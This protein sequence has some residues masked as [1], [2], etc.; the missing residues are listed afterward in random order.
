MKHFTL[1]ALCLAC[2]FFEHCIS[3]R[4]IRN[5]AVTRVG[6]AELNLFKDSDCLADMCDRQVTLQSFF[7]KGFLLPL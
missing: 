2:L 7:A 5:G 3:L 6:V 1:V 4:S